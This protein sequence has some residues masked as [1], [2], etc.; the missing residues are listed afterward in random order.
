MYKVPTS[1]SV[2]SCWKDI[3]PYITL[4]LNSA[5]TGTGRLEEFSPRRLTVFDISL[6][7][8]AGSVENHPGFGYKRVSLASL[9][10]QRRSRS[11]PPSSKLSITGMC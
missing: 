6:D 7:L 8:V 10:T 5:K 9:G 2:N 3:S 4:Y 11:E 1:V